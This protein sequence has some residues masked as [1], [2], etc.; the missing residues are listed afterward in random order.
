M[1]YPSKSK[2][3]DF[4]PALNHPNHL[5]NQ[6]SLNQDNIQNT[7]FILPSNDGEAKRA[8]EILDAVNAPRMHISQQGWGAVLDREMSHLNWDLAK[9]ASKVLVFE[10][11]GKRNKNGIISTEEEFLLRGLDLVIVDHHYYKWVDRYRP[12]SS[13]EQLC[14]YIGWQPDFTD[15]AI[16]VNDRSYIPGLKKLGLSHD[17]IRDV[18]I[19]DLIAQGNSAQ[20][21]KEQIDRAPGEIAS[22]E[23]YKKGDLWIIEK[24][25]VERSFLLQELAIRTEDGIVHVLEIQPKKL[26][27]SGSPTA[28]D[29]LLGLNY[30]NM[31]FRPGYACYGG[32]DVSGSR[33]WGFRPA[34]GGKGITPEFIELVIQIIQE[35]IT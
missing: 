21:I 3:L 7:W 5:S 28:V 27:F 8:I 32:G 11:P 26:S 16:S 12:E 4:S 34:N 17:E 23:Q 35:S 29:K 18:R 2:R 6:T 25:E 9:G 14:E 1:V 15:T 20:Y 30:K 13:L 10:I 22:L 33:F 31:G 24:P 19:Y